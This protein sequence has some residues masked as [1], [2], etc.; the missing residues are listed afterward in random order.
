[1]EPL[2]ARLQD[3]DAIVRWAAAEA[4]GALQDPRAVEPL[5]ARLQDADPSVR[6]AA[7]L[8]LGALRDPRALESLAAIALRR[9]PTRTPKTETQSPPRRRPR[10]GVAEAREALFRLLYPEA[11]R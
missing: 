10:R 9:K 6:W 1:V 4:L 11:V 5:L 2:L 8:A 7:A 3:A